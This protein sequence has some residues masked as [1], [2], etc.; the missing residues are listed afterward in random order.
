[1]TALTTSPELARVAHHEID[2][3]RIGRTV[4]AEIDG[5]IEFGPRQSG[6]AVR[7]GAGD[8]ILDRRLTETQ[9]EFA[10]WCRKLDHLRGYFGSAR[11]IPPGSKFLGLLDAKQEAV[12]DDGRRLDFAGPLK[13]PSSCLAATE[14]LRKTAAP[15]KSKIC[16]IPLRLIAP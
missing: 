8:Y 1:M 16:H 6:S 7:A 13:V 4:A 2:R 5:Q 3:V 15:H 11:R 14:N 10:Q 12:A 9:H